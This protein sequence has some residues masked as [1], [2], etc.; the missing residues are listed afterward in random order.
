LAAVAAG[1]ARCSVHL[2]A[3][4]CFDFWNGQRYAGKQW[5]EVRPPH[6][7]IPTFVK[8]GA[9]LPLAEATVLHK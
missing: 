4:R 1:Q 8:S 2:P 3:G 7:Q 6:G 9:I 5:V